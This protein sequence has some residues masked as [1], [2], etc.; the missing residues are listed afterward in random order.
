[1]DIKFSYQ[2][3][4]IFSTNNTQTLLACPNITRKTK[5]NTVRLKQNKTKIGRKKPSNKG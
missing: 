3:P 4:T 5:T 1:M 2:Y